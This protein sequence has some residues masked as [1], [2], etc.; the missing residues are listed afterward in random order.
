MEKKKNN[1]IEKVENIA[2]GIPPVAGEPFATNQTGINGPVTAPI[3]TDSLTLSEARESEAKARAI[4]KSRAAELKRERKALEVQA[5]KA[6]KEAKIKAK[7]EE[8]QRR[9]EIYKQREKHLHERM[10]TDAKMR[11]ER[12]RDRRNRGLGGW[13]TAV[14]ILGVT[15]LV[16]GSLLG[17][18]M[19]TDYLDIG[20][21]TSTSADGQRA[22]YDFVGYVDNMETNM[23]KL[24]VSSDSEGR[25]K[26]LGQLSVQSNLADAALSELPIKDESKYYTSKYINQVGDYAKYLNNRLIDGYSLDKNDYDMLRKL[27][28]INVEI[29]AALTELSAS[30]DSG[31][32]F[33]KLSAAEDTDAIISG[34]NGLEESARE[35][36]EMIYDGPFSDG[37]ERMEPRGLNF[38]EV[39]E[40][41]VRKNF[42]ELFGEY[43][44][45]TIEVIG[46]TEADNIAAYNLRADID[47][48]ELF[49]QMT[50]KGGK[51]LLFN[52]FKDCNE[53][54]YGEDECREIAYEF[55]EKAG[56]DDMNCVWSY[57]AGATAYFNFVYN[58]GGID[59]YP[60][61][62][63]VNVCMERGLVSAIDADAYYKN[64]TKRVDFTPSRSMEEA[65][66]A[67]NGELKVEKASL[68]IIPIG[69][70]KE[71]LAYEFIC[72]Y[73][74]STFFVYI[75]AETLRQA[76]IFKV[77]ET[78]QGRLLI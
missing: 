40:F 20:Q 4:R 11:E 17:F 36:P 64:H 37:L 7:A 63:K 73:E 50:V 28:D 44:F 25:Q 32:D 65:A 13:I 69:N 8:R 66:E 14:V 42:E 67:L 27:Y 6:N 39:D 34:F 55:L 26:I 71:R 43:D 22:F 48:G 59:V 9:A 60:D 23:S 62:V 68:A 75:D 41:A 5:K 56:F 35:Y 33:K 49:A 30:L 18:N 57:T 77:V 24:L 61:M 52:A 1:A 70:G 51:L 78:D 3:L 21:P 2:N 10:V 45:G 72:G 19:F 74:E 54:N 15:T 46:K 47:G 12:R 29:K 53:E 38:D 31:Y 16:L 58:Y 76:D